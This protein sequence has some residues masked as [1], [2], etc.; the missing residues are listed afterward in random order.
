MPLCIASRCIGTHKG[1][2]LLTSE[3][4]L[5][6][7]REQAF[8]NI[9]TIKKLELQTSKVLKTFEVSPSN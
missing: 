7:L 9:V 5:A 4:I 2:A 1:A 8:K 3:L 6:E